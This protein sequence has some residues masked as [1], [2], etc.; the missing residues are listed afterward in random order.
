MAIS[1]HRWNLNR[2]SGTLIAAAIVAISLPGC[3]PTGPGPAEPSPS[4]V[5][6]PSPVALTEQQG[7]PSGSPLPE[8]TELDFP[9]TPVGWVDD[10]GETFWIVTWNSSS[11]PFIATTLDAQDATTVGVRFEQRPAEVCT[12]DL[13]PR[14]HRF[15]IPEGVDRPT[16]ALVE[17]V[18]SAFGEAEAERFTIPLEP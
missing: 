11:C 13:A 12:A 9:V 14:A 6:A 3:S 1:A 7:W 17:T 15:A 10:D 8:P 18:A 4:G 2:L 16:S 5:D